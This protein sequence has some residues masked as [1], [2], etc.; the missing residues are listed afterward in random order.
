MESVMTHRLE[1]LDIDECLRLLGAS[2]LGRLAVVVGEQPLVFPVNYAMYG[3]QVVFRTDPGT[4][5]HAATNRRVAFEIDGTDTRYHDGWSVLVVGTAHE[6]LD[7][8][9]LL[10]LEQLPLKPWL[11]GPKSHW[12]CIR[13]GAITGRR[14]TH[15]VS[16]GSD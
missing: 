13:G 16:D 10:D 14:I 12:M 5:L 11:S 3:P 9:R 15:V 2:F 6:E 1:I 8:A 7:P 4:K